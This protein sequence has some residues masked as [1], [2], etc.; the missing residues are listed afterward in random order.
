MDLQHGFGIA[1]GGRNGFHDL[2]EK[3]LQTGRIV[4]DGEMSYA[5][6][7]VG[8]N[9]GKIELIFR[10]VEVDEEVVNFVEHGGRPRVGTINLVENHDR[11]KLR[12]QGL[13]QN[14]T[15]LR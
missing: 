14:V 11:R 13:L 1:G 9:H 8:V 15:R 5:E 4:A 3:R 2:F 12:G 7:R 6:F 10:R